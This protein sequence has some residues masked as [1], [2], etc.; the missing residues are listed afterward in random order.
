MK[1]LIIYHTDYCGP[2]R[3]Y[4]AKVLPDIMAAFPEQVEA[5][6]AVNYLNE[7]KRLK[8]KHVP[9]AVL[10]DGDEE[11]LL[12]HVPSLEEAAAFLQEGNLA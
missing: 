7:C 12:Q 2:C 4:I 5:R 9:A 10:V 11:T 6:N 3:H 1:K 8:I